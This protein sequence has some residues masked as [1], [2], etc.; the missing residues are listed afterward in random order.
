MSVGINIAGLCFGGFLSF[1]LP[2]F[3]KYQDGDLFTLYSS[4]AISVL[5]LLCMSVHNK[6]DKPYDPTSKK[7][8]LTK[9]QFVFVKPKR[10]VCG[11]IKDTLSKKEYISVA[12]AYALI[13]GGFIYMTISMPMSLNLLRSCKTNQFFIAVFYI[14]GIIGSMIFSIIVDR[15]HHFK[16]FLLITSLISS[17]I[18]IISR[19]CIVIF[20]SLNV[21]F[22][23]E[24]SIVYLICFNIVEG[25][26]AVFYF[27]FVSIGI[28]YI[29]EVS[30][31][32]EEGV[33]C[34]IAEMLSRVVALALYGIVYLMREKLMKQNFIE[35]AVMSAS[36]IFGIIF[37]IVSKED[38]SRIEK[39]KTRIDSLEI[40]MNESFSKGL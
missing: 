11:F 35:V 4:I 7:S 2:N 14:S 10:T 3:I 23:T 13:K 30:Y 16:K 5:C 24:D 1:L 28:N 15:T 29:C 31:P 18:F 40:N 34:G 27:G 25:I 9:Q 21:P 36:I 22:Y 38:L 19:I 6:K 20:N 37:V 8:L 17:L 33:P 32:N 26:I 12:L 39:E